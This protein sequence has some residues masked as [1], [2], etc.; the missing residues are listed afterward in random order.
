MVTVF[1][2]ATEVL[3]LLPVFP[4]YRN[5]LPDAGGISGE[6]KAGREPR[7]VKVFALTTD[8]L[9]FITVFPIYRNGLPDAVGI[10]D[11]AYTHLTLPT[12]YSV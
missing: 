3:S 2:L 8:A 7:S 12:T 5:R 4:I 11:A 1:A 10:S 9:S 6:A